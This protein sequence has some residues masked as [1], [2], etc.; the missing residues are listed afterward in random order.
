MTPNNSF[1]GKGTQC[2]ESESSKVAKIVIS[3]QIVDTKFQLPLLSNMCKQFDSFQNS[4][5]I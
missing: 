4:Y 3:F 1:L 2:Y 5:D